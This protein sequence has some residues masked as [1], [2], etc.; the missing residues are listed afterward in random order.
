MFKYVAKNHKSDN[1]LNYLNRDQWKSFSTKDFIKKTLSVA[2][3]L[4]KI[5]VTHKTKVAILLNLL[6]YW[7]IYDFAIQLNGGISVPMFTNISEENFKFQI[8]HSEVKFAFVD[9]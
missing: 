2:A 5:G 1:C 7:L 6:L 3:Y 9:G 4:R 8:N